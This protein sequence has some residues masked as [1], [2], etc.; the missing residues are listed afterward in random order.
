[1]EIL[2]KSSG[3][4]L[5]LIAI[6][7]SIAVIATFPNNIE[8]CIT[9]FKESGTIGIAYLFGSLIGDVIFIFIILFMIKSGLK[10]IKKDRKSNNSI[11]QIEL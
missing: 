11:K 5:I 6:L 1:M 4:I 10:L 2:K 3:Y 8:Q 7:L 9:K